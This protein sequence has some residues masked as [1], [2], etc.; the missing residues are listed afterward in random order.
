VTEQMCPH[1]SETV[2]AQSAGYAALQCDGEFDPLQ[3]TVFVGCHLS[4]G[5]SA[6]PDPVGTPHADWP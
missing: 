3:P 2:P 4:A 6:E 1:L 5:L